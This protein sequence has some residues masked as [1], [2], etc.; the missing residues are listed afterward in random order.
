MIQSLISILP[1]HEISFFLLRLLAPTTSAFPVPFPIKC[2][3]SWEASA[4][5]GPL[6][7]SLVILQ[8]PVSFQVEPIGL[9][10]A[11]GKR[12]GWD[13][14]GVLNNMQ[15]RGWSFDVVRSVEFILLVEWFGF[16]TE[17]VNNWR[18]V[19]SQQLQRCS[20]RRR[21]RRPQLFCFSTKAVTSNGTTNCMSTSTKGATMKRPPSQALKRAWRLATASSVSRHGVSSLTVL[22]KVQAVQ[23]VLSHARKRG[24]PSNKL[25]PWSILPQNQQHFWEAQRHTIGSSEARSK[26]LDTP[27][28]SNSLQAV[29]GWLC[30]ASERRTW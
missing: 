18:T 20:V 23:L 24:C 7:Q 12:A 26:S 9:G 1:G 19:R 4:A 30:Y 14:N 3:Q 16:P 22:S 15:Q 27:K 17:H 8:D 11:A 5:A 10:D 21:P 28:D 25:D 6:L 13:P 29:D 2:P